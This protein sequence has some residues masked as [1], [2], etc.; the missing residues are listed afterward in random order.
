MKNN[1]I[2]SDYDGY[3]RNTWDSMP[4]VK[5]KKTVFACIYL[6]RSLKHNFSLRK[7]LLSTEKQVHVVAVVGTH[8]PKFVEKLHEQFDKR[9]L[10]VRLN[11]SFCFVSELKP[12][13][14]Q[15]HHVIPNIKERDD[16]AAFGLVN[17]D[18]RNL[19]LIM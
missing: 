3:Y 18:L 1:K 14:S 19:E 7:I 11:V 2:H 9:E 6:I 12:L 10:K 13:T 8:C 4:Y 15:V 5:E 16:N 17:Y